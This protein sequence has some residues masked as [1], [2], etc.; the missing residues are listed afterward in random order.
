MLLVDITERKCLSRCTCHMPKYNM[1][2]YIGICMKVLVPMHVGMRWHAQL[3]G[4]MFGTLWMCMSL[5]PCAF[6]FAQAGE[7]F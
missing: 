7:C 5:N 3:H 4:R 1:L 6:A 2:A